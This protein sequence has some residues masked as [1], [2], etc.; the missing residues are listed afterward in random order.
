MKSTWHVAGSRRQLVPCDGG[1][2]LLLPGACPSWSQ[3][4]E[5]GVAM[6]GICPRRE[7]VTWHR[8]VQR[9]RAAFRYESD[10]EWKDFQV[11]VTRRTCPGAAGKQGFCASLWAV[12]KA[13]LAAR[14]KTPGNRGR[15]THG[16]GVAHG[17]GT[18]SL[19]R[20]ET[21]SPATNS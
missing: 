18:I 5:S 9:A 7:N 12:W 10:A 14:S 17:G 20:V 8:G 6:V 19:C 15:G 4:P 3:S 21:F 13:T 16:L 1:L 2:T 11:T